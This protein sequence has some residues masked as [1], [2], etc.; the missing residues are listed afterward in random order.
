MDKNKSDKINKNLRS[1][2]IAIPIALILDQFC[3]HFLPLI[4]KWL[5]SKI[6]NYTGISNDGHINTTVL[7]L[8]LMIY[9]I[10]KD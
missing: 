7:I 5:M 1:Y 2:Q 9:E 6:P 3:L 8:T 10:I 4:D